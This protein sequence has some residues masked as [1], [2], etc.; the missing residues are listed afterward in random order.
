[1]ELNN[2][3]KGS[4]YVAIG[5]SCYGILASLV[6]LSYK[7]GHSTAEI[8]SAQF[9]IGL[10]CMA[11]LC[12]VIK[13]HFVKPTIKNKIQLILWGTSMGFTSVLYYLCVKFL[14]ANIAVVFLMQSV[15][16]GVVIEAIR[17]K[18]FPDL[19]KTLAVILVLIGTFLT[20][21]IWKNFQLNSLGFFFGFLSALSFS[22]TMFGT[23]SVATQCSPYKRSFYMLCGG[24]VIVAF[25]TLFTQVLPHAGYNPLQLSDKIIFPQAFRWELFYSYGIPLALFATVIPPI[26]MNKGFPKTGVGLGSILSALELPISATFAYFILKETLTNTQ[27]IGVFIILFSVLLIHYKENKL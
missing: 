23:F 24:I 15:W 8:S 9:S 10:F 17:L 7:E 13:D 1:M 16:I 22:A 27:W 26:F 6:K 11:I 3:L 19:R 14:N 12:L 4:I 18:K 2:K 20:T 5:A 25:F 21:Q